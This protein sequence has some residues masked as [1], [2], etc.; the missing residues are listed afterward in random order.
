MRLL[1]I[2]PIAVDVWGGDP[3]M[4]ILNRHDRKRAY[5]EEFQAI[6]SP[7]REHAIARPVSATRASLVK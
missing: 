3:I 1:Y 2:N 7:G 6:L 4:C 5:L